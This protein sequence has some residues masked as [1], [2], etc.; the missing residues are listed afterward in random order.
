MKELRSCGLWALM[1]TASVCLLY[2]SEPRSGVYGR[3]LEGEAGLGLISVGGLYWGA[4]SSCKHL[5]EGSRNP[6]FLHI[7]HID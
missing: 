5:G 6:H 3:Q 2:T 4:V 1:E 7:L